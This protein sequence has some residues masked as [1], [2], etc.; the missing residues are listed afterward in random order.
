[1]PGILHEIE[2][3]L[4]R[5]DIPKAKTLISRALNERPTETIRAQLLVYRARAHLSGN[6]PEPCLDDLEAVQRMAHELFATPETQELFADGHLMRFEQSPTGSADQSDLNRAIQIY[7]AVITESPKYN[8]LGWVYYQ[9]GRALLAMNNIEEAIDSLQK[10]LN[11]L[12]RRTTLKAFCYER[13]GFIEFFIRREF[14]RS[15][16][17]L[18]LA[19]AVYP[20]EEDTGWLASVH[21]LTARVLNALGQTEAMVYAI[22]TATRLASESNQNQPALADSLLSAGELLSVVNWYEREALDYLQ[23][24]LQVIAKPDSIDVTWSRVHEIIGDMHFRLNEYEAA[25]KAYTTALKFNPF[26]PWEVSIYYR[27]AQCHYQLGEYDA[28]VT[29]IERLLESAQ[30]DSS[31]ITDYRVYDILGNAEFALARYNDAAEHYQKAL[32]LAPPSLEGIE[33]IR[34]YHHFA[35]QLLDNPQ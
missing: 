11:G 10:G 33:K 30:S 16:D 8:N 19:V 35:C 5:S 32:E 24:Y 1:M 4:G 27:A 20:P 7:R 3:H 34:L 28:A 2:D 15:L 12:S 29:M 13:L 18:E 21:L 31:P 17:L 14:K 25:A 22:G 23:Q 26:H 6:C 9:L